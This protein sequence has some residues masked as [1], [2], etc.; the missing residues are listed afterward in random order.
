[1]VGGKKK[2]EKDTRPGVSHDE[3]E[4]DEEQHQRKKKEQPSELG[5]LNEPARILVG[6]FWSLIDCTF[7]LFLWTNFLDEW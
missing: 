4:E 2:K 6:L 3:Q 1:M 5:K 7:K